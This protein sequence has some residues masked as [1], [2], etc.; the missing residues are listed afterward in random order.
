MRCFGSASFHFGGGAP[1]FVQDGEEAVAPRVS[2]RSSVFY[3]C[4]STFMLKTFPQL[5]PRRLDSEKESGSENSRK[6]IVLSQPC[7]AS[8]NGVRPLL[9]ERQSV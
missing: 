5:S 1:R 9:A 2:A 7:T 6:V 4:I 8:G 3:T